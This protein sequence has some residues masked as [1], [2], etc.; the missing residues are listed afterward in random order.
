[1]CMRRGIFPSLA[2]AFSILAAIPFVFRGDD[3]VGQWI[4]GSGSTSINPVGQCFNEKPSILPL[5]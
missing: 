5:N 2:F 3:M 4:S 1:M